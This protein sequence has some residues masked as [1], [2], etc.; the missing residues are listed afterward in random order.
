MLVYKCRR[1][2]D[3][4]ENV[5]ITFTV[6]EKWL[7]KTPQVLQRVFSNNIATVVKRG[8]SPRRCH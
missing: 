8:F 5:K 4:K 3:S 6:K 2:T 7:N 1:E